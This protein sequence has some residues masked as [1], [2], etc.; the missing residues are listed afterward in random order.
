MLKIFKN[1]QMLKE[2]IKKLKLQESELDK[3]NENYL[4]S[5]RKKLVLYKECLIQSLQQNS[6]VEEVDK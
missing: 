3:K 5:I 6:M 4:N 1:F 2:Y